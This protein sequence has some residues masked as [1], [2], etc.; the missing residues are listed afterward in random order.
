MNWCSSVYSVHMLHWSCLFYAMK[1]CASIRAMVMRWNFSYIW[2]VFSG[3]CEVR[4]YTFIQSVWIWWHPLNVVY[5]ISS[6][7]LQFN[8]YCYQD[9]YESF[10]LHCMGM[11]WGVSY[12]FLKKM[13]SCQ[14]PKLN[15]WMGLNCANLVVY[16]EM[17]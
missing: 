8:C 3:T 10:G 1:I 17:W 16:E 5:I 15:E 14:P 9:L 7:Q 6:W 12:F 11:Y 4:Y 2:S 13:C